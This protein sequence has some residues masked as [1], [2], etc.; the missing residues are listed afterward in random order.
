M[1]AIELAAYLRERLHTLGMTTTAAAE[2]SGISRQTWHKLLR[3]DIHEAKLSTIIQVAETLE[4]NPLSMLR[5]YF[6]G[7][8]ISYASIPLDEEN[9]FVSGFVTDITYPDN[10]TVEPGQEFEKIWEVVNLGKSAWVNLQLQWVDEQKPKPI[11]SSRTTSLGRHPTCHLIPLEPRIA[12]PLT[13][14]GEH[15]RLKVRLRA[16]DYPCN[17]TSYWKAVDHDGHSIFP[18][19][20]GLYCLVKVA[21]S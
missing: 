13:Q 12:I 6:H 2:H 7:K 9:Q 1:S 18:K 15:V 8:S 5:I 3:A 4:T 16:P 20:S 19:L 14:P 17:A 10:S 21:P 11:T